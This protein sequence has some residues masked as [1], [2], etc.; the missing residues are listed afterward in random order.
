MAKRRKRKRSFGARGQTRLEELQEHAKSGGLYVASYSPGDGVTR[1][2]FFERPGNA[3]FGPDS[4]ICTEF[5]LKRAWRYLQTG[6][7]T[8][9]RRRR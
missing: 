1:Y 8:V 3:Y 6:T 5:G 7:C 2:R 9:M 4:G